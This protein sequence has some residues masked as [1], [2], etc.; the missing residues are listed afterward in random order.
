M[1]IEWC[2]SEGYKY[3]LWQLNETWFCFGFLISVILINE[4]SSQWLILRSHCVLIK[5]WS[6]MSIVSFL[7]GAF[8]GI[9]AFSIGNCCAL[10]SATL[11]YQSFVNALVYFYSHSFT[12]WEVHF[13][14]SYIKNDRKTHTAHFG[15][16]QSWWSVI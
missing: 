4:G 15:M 1:Y 6:S 2:T 10:K 3:W 12:V 14:H 16:W 9:C 7:W 5:C 11:C 13:K 8:I